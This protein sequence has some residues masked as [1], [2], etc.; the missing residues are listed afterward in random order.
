[1]RGFNTAKVGPKDGDDYIGG[2]YSTS[3]SAEVQLPNILPESYK[4]DFSVFVDTGNVWAVDYSN[5]IDDS[6][7]IRSSVGFSANVY[8][9]VGPLSFTIAESI[10]QATSDETETFNFRLGTSF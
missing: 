4:T 1:L 7:K 2:N 6:N 10:T 8:T 3:L 9:T 5:S